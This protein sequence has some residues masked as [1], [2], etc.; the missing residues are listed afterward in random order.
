MFK[1]KF[2]LIFIFKVLM[3]FHF[4]LL[5]DLDKAKEGNYTCMA[6]NLWN[7]DQVTY[8][9]LVLMAPDAPIL[10]LLHTTSRTLHLR[11]R[12]SD[13]GGAPIQGETLIIN[14]IIS[15]TCLCHSLGG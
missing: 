8:Q 1:C 7:E 10:E 3:L 6:K 13:D 5:T 2:T 15:T 4:T 11:W 14:Q 12:A 9:V